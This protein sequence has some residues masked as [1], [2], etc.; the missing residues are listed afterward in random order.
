LGS[1]ESG[2]DFERRILEIYQSC[3]STEEITQAFEHLQKELDDSIQ[4]KMQQTRQKL[5]E[6]FDEEVHHRLK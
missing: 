4:N 2:V 6:H 3:R 1:L 5:L